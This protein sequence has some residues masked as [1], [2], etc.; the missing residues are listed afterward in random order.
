MST[1]A[2]VTEVLGGKKTLGARPKTFLDW[3]A[4]IL[5]GMPVE[6]AEALKDGIAVAD[7]SFAELIGI[8]A[9]TL[10]RARAGKARLD[11]VASDRLF[12]LARIVALAAEVLE[13]EE[14]AVRWLKRPQP[15]LGGRTPLS[16]LVTDAGR[17]EVEKLLLRLEHGVYT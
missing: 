14:P 16:L 6:S 5:A 9:K 3:Q 12:R 13:G 4:L 2:A 15:G 10:S 7:K 17:D 8:S 11:P 1:L